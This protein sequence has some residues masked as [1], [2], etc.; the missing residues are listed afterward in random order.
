MHSEYSITL[1]FQLTHFCPAVTL[2]A[3]LIHE[4]SEAI[5]SRLCHRLRVSLPGGDSLR[6]PVGCP[7]RR[8]RMRPDFSPQTMGQT[9]ECGAVKAT[10][11][12]QESPL[13]CLN[14]GSTVCLSVHPPII[15]CVVILFLSYPYTK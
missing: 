5:H 12:D 6:V 7:L 3:T 2:L 13:L 9:T 1:S 11:R 14:I 10:Q 4:P 15:H 8:H